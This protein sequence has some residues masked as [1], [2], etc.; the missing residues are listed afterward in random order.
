MKKLMIAAAAALLLTG[1]GDASKV[2][3]LIEKNVPSEN[4]ISSEDTDD[5]SA[6]YPADRE[7]APPP[8]IPQIDEAQL[9]NGDIDID[10]TMLNA[11]MLYAQVFEMLGDPE[12]Y[13][14][15]T[16]RAKGT[17]L[18]ADDPE[19]GEPS[20]AVFIADASACCA[21]G[22]EF[23]C[24]DDPEDL[25]EIDAPITVTGTFNA[26]KEGVFTYCELADAAIEAG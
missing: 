25:P 21:Q 4:K 22:I 3:S 26:Y 9:V 16:V 6:S 20:F 1:C 5:T 23:R 18:C 17:F 14:G 7:T 13:Q 11:N 8:R 15:K 10:L 19:T 24:N 12:K 2:D